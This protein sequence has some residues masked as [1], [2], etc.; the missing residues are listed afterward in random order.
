MALGLVSAVIGARETGLGRDVDVNLY[1]T[2]LYNLSYL[3]AW[4][5][6]TDYDPK[7]IARS[8]HPSLVPCQLYR[9]A[10]GWI[11]IMCN[12]EK[13]WTSL[14]CEIGNPDLAAEPQYKTF[15][16]RLAERDALTVVLDRELSQRTTQDWLTRLQGKVPVAPVR[17]PREALHDA[18]QDK[19]GKVTDVWLQNGAAYQLLNSPI[20]HGNTK[21]RAC[22]P[23]G[24]DT[25]DI[26]REAGYSD[27]EILE[28]Q[29]ANLI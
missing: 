11:F 24:F 2:A 7:R 10:D 5:L 23:M 4:A 12:K 29:N 14:C 25:K 3:S 8:A 26:L 1:D 9:T 19:S 6:N 27:Q 17:T 15:K 20:Q 22:S 18:R 28:F 16:H 21:A 13:F